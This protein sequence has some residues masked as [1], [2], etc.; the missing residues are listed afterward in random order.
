[1]PFSCTESSNV[2]P[3]SRS[4]TICVS[5]RSS[6]NVSPPDTVITAYSASLERLSCRRCRTPQTAALTM[7]TAITSASPHL[8]CSFRHNFKAVCTAFRRRKTGFQTAGYQH[9]IL[10]RHKYKIK[11]ASA[12]APECDRFI[13]T[14]HKKC[15]GLDRL[16][17]VTS[18]GERRSLR[19]IDRFAP[20]FRSLDREYGDTGSHPA[21]NNVGSRLRL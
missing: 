14:H 10:I 7:Q 17:P 3:F 15:R 11:T 4:V 20:V 16:G 8:R 2:Y 5:R 18:H 12:I 6:R 1:M 9:G 13:R 21:Q 19:N